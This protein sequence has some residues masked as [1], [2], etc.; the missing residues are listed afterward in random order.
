[1][2]KPNQKLQMLVEDGT[3]KRFLMQAEQS[4]R[5]YDP[6]DVDGYC[7]GLCEVCKDEAKPVLPTVCRKMYEIAAETE[8]TKRGAAEVLGVNRQTYLDTEKRLEEGSYDH[9][10]RIGRG[11]EK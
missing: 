8:P 2:G 3:G 1:M 7:K 11:E 4:V 9:P 5:V 10:K 6:E